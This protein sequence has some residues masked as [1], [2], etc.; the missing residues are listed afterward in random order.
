MT[1]TISAADA[2]P[3]ERDGDALQLR[4]HLRNDAG[5]DRPR[6]RLT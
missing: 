1:Q 5:I 4:D 6:R 3:D 2:G